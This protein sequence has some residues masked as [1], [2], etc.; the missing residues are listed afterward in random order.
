M[1]SRRT[2]RRVGAVLAGVLAVVILSTATDLV[3]H[4]TRVFPSWGEPMSARLFVLATAYRLVFGVAGSYVAARLAPDRPMRHALAVGAV[5]LALSIAGTLAT[6]NR[7][8]AFGPHWYP[9]GL[10]ATAMPCAW[11][12]G[13]LHAARSGRL[14]RSGR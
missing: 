4:A 11:A 8:P 3:M 2:L 13:R 12:G 5:G 7:G 1:S 9:L 6:W 14:R 10:V